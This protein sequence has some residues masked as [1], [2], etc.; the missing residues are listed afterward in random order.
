MWESVTGWR[1]K[2][3]TKKSGL[4]ITMNCAQTGFFSEKS[5]RE[6]HEY[7][8]SLR[9]RTRCFKQ[10]AYREAS[11]FKQVNTEKSGVNANEESCTWHRQNFAFSIKSLRVITTSLQFL[12]KPLLPSNAKAWSLIQDKECKLIQPTPKFSKQTW[13]DLCCFWKTGL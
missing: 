6:S 5:A 1:F 9:T 12:N 4:I 13:Y 10:I 7:Q 8:S 11:C 2:V 3:W